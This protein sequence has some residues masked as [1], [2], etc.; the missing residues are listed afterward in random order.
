MSVLDIGMFTYIGYFCDLINVRRNVPSCSF[1]NQNEEANFQP[2]L[3]Q[4]LNACLDL[5]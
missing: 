4:F 3:W 5:L 1:K 2:I